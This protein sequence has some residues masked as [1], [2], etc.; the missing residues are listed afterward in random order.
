MTPNRLYQNI[1]TILCNTIFYVND[2]LYVKKI[3]TLRQ[4]RDNREIITIRHLFNVNIIS[5]AFFVA[6]V[7]FS[8]T[9]IHNTANLS[10]WI[11]RF[12]YF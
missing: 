10:K 3:K 1:Q 6:F 7:S 12:Y 2:I 4:S 5:F 11:T 9:Q 8:P